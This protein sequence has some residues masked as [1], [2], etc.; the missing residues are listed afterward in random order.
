M[1]IEDLPP[2]ERKRVAEFVLSQLDKWEKAE[3]EWFGERVTVAP[4][5]KEIPDA[6]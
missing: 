1:K 6:R 2:P 4:R 5:T 3:R